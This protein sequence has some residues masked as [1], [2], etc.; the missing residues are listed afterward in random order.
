MSVPSNLD[1]ETY[2]TEL[3]FWN[4]FKSEF[5]VGIPNS[6]YCRVKLSACSRSSLPVFPFVLMIMLIT[7][8]CLYFSPIKE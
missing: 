3:L 2:I 7:C 5:T 4:N 8:R 1:T 6:Q